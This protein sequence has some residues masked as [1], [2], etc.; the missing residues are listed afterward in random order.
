MNWFQ[1]GDKVERINGRH[2]GM[3]IG[4]TDHV[5][6]TFRDGITLEHYV[7]RGGATHSRVCFKL[8][9]RD[10]EPYVEPV[11][12][13]KPVTIKEEVGFFPYKVI[14]KGVWKS[15][16]WRWQVLCPNG[17]IV[18]SFKDAGHARVLAKLL[19]EGNK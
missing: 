2:C 13:V 3:R 19:K 5:K 4:D 18:G 16:N 15:A 12:E 8:L 10:G 11:E 9:E 6:F 14:G 1:I 7:G 17:L